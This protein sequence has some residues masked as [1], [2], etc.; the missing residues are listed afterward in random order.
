MYLAKVY[1]NFQLQL[2]M[3]PYGHRR[4]EKGKGNMLLQELYCVIS[5]LPIIS[6]TTTTTDAS[7][8]S[9]FHVKGPMSPQLIFHPKNKG[10][11]QKL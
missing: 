5:T 1:V 8:H 11:K 6:T 2:Y 10:I 3:G 9:H 7:V 4:W